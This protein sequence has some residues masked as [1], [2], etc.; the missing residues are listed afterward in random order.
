MLITRNAL[1]IH[2]EVFFITFFVIMYRTLIWSV[3]LMNLLACMSPWAD[4]VMIIKNS[5]GYSRRT[6]I[7]TAVWFW[8]GMIAH[9]SYCLLWLAVLISNSIILFNIIKIAWWLYLIY[10]WIQS[11]TTE[12]ELNVAD[13]ENKN[14]VE[15]SRTQ[16]LKSWFLTNLLN[17]KATLFMLAIFTVVIWPETP[18]WVLWV[19]AVWI[20]STIVIWFSIVAVFLTIPKVQN[21]YSKVQHYLNKIFGAILI[22]FG[23]KVISSRQQ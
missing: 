7:W 4:F 10:I 18:A 16:A 8:F 9:I 12:T 3:L 20:V 19:I 5:V 23:I 22:G 1:L 11:L 6:W 15:L 17:P 13:I 21:L 2:L 14:N